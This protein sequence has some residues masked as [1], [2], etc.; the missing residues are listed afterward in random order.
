MN[1]TIRARGWEVSVGDA[2][3]RLNQNVFGKLDAETKE[4]LNS[5][6]LNRRIKQ[7][8]KG[9]NL[10]EQSAMEYLSEQNGL[11]RLGLTLR[12]HAL[13]L[14]LAN[15]VRYIPDVTGFSPKHDKLHAWEIKGKHAWD[16]A[17]VKLKV[18]AHEWPNIQ[19][20]LMWKDDCVW[21]TQHILA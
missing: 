14:L 6:P 9:P 5:A 2:V 21:Q 8:T 17:I 18:A 20:Y 11:S 1:K 12:H 4:I 19:F 7:K 15:G 10:L 13:T 3:R 16:D